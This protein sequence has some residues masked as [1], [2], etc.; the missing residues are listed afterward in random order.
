[1]KN[2]IAQILSSLKIIKIYYELL[3]NDK[4]L[5]KYELAPAYWNF[6]WDNWTIERGLI[7]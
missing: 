6:I 1:M 7:K 2:W 4:D 3:D 5:Y